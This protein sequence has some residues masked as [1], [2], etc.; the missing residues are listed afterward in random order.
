[1]GGTELLGGGLC[2]LSTFE[3]VLM[4]LSGLVVIFMSFVLVIF[5]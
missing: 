3:H 1:M 4:F 2:S 5:S